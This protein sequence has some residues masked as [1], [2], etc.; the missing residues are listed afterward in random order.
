MEVEVLQNER[1]E[2][3]LADIRRLRLHLGDLDE[4]L[5]NYTTFLVQSLRILTHERKLMTDSYDDAMNEIQATIGGLQSHLVHIE[6]ANKVF[7]DDSSRILELHEL[8]VEKERSKNA[9]LKKQ[10]T[11]T[12]EKMEKQDQKVEDEF[13]TKVHDTLE[14]V[15]K[16]EKLARQML[17][18]NKAKIEQEITDYKNELA[19]KKL[20]IKNAQFRFKH[21][22]TERQH[23]VEIDTRDVEKLRF[24]LAKYEKRSK[25]LHRYEKEGKISGIQRRK[26]KQQSQSQSQQRESSSK[27][28]SKSKSKQS[29]KQRGMKSKKSQKKSKSADGQKIRSEKK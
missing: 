10:L 1:N 16:K 2:A 21:A 6:K 13:S 9:K 26:S 27:S 11:D 4:N 20:E 22:D 3:I 24:I 23:D 29:K 8:D 5:A 14:P 15:E 7:V 25:K 18:L 19:R 12:K 28:K 17:L